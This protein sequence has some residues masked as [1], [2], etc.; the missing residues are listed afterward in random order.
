M[1]F[2]GDPVTAKVVDAT[3]E[4]FV[5]ALTEFPPDSE[6]MIVCPAGVL[7]PLRPRTADTVI[8]CPGAALVAPVYVTVL[9]LSKTTVS[10]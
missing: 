7:M 2:R 3:P 10:L 6:K 1:A 4:L 9:V 8:V 5:V